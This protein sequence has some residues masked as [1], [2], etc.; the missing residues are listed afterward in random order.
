MRQQ[1]FEQYEV[2]NFCRPGFVSRHNSN[3]WRQV[4][5]LGLGPSAH[6]FRGTSRQFNIASN[7][8]YLQAL[9]QDQIPA[10]VEDLTPE[11]Q[12]NEYVMTTLRTAWGCDLKVVQQQ[13]GFDL[14]ALQG[15]YLQD[16]VHRGLV[17]MEEEVLYLTDQGKLLADQIAMDLFVLPNE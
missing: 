5:Y 2:S 14:G 7:A 17:R 6:S 8:R 4:P 3:Y 12:A 16:L 15:P 9:E 13:Y 11:D 1:G 10:T